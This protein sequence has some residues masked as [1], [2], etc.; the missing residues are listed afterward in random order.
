[1][2][3][4]IINPAYFLKNDK[5][6]VIITKRDYV[7][8]YIEDTYDL[9]DVFSFIHPLNAQ[10]L[11][12]FNGEDDLEMITQKTSAYFQIAENEMYNILLKY[13]ENKK[14]FAIIY[15]D[16]KIVI[17]QNMVIRKSD[18]IKKYN[19][20]NPESF[21]CTEKPDFETVR[22][23][24]PM[25]ILF[26]PTMQCYTDCIY[27]YANR[28]MNSS[29]NM[30]LQQIQSIINQ[31]KEIEVE[32]IDL[33]GGEVLLHPYYKEIITMLLENNYY[34]SIST[35]IPLSEKIIDDLK[36]IGISSIQISLDSVNPNTLTQ[37]LKV[38]ETYLES[39]AHTLQY[40][41]KKE[42]KVKIHSIVTSYN[43]DLEEFIN[44]I[45]WL[46]KYSCVYHI[47]ISPAGYSLYKTNFLQYR[48]SETFMN[49]LSSYIDNIR[50]KFSRIS[51]QVSGG[52]FKK[53]YED[54][55]SIFNKRALCSGNVRSLVILPDGRVTVCEELYENEQFI[56]GDLTKQT[57]MEI[58]NSPKANDLFYIN[59][60][61]ISDDSV[62]KK[63][64]TFDS[65]RQGLGVCWKEI[66]MAYGENNWDY[67]D[68]RCPKAPEMYND[69]CM[70]AF[71]K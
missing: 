37:L 5:N 33:N 6:R 23:N 49:T 25:N 22:L 47:Q 46:S 29:G 2:S 28:K 58:W 16:T 39:M 15:D 38:K 64:V 26:L 4:Y 48:T 19:T 9:H 27:C 66:L 36:S 11:S 69:I 50:E 59:P 13:I 32:N 43:S 52:N 7:E 3:K 70:D 61:T 1:M 31:A 56:I 40:L 8:K 21:I 12:F 68:A 65:C 44:L 30:T 60:D 71:S 41:C 24:S 42:F 55:I 63:C 10:M 53:D 54:K 35:K 51:F 18:H 14:S 45:N 67:P 62:C 57:I 20:Y 17:P 34:P